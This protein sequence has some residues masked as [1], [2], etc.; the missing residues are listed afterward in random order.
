M[1]R[2]DVYNHM[3][4]SSWRKYA[5]ELEAENAA[6]RVS[7]EKHK[8]IAEKETNLV[9][10]LLMCDGMDNVAIAA[11][12]H[13]GIRFLEAENA[14]LQERLKERAIE[15]DNY[16]EAIGEVNEEKAALREA[17]TEFCDRRDRGQVRSN[18]T[19]RKFKALLQ[20]LEGKE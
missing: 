3:H 2:P 19:Y 10:T 20:G 15:K 6:L 5:E 9:E 18:Y 14:A 1:S 11:K 8:A 4:T 12:L 13:S 17:M 16:E 7:R